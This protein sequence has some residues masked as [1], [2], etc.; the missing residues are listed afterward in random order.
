M[1]SFAVNMLE[2]LVIKPQHSQISVLQDK[3]IYNHCFFVL[4]QIL[5]ARRRRDDRGYANFETFL[6]IA[7][8]SLSFITHFVFET[9]LC[10]P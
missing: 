10:D 9:L 2:E 4:F 5:H 7:T 8:C 3:K 6:A 1:V